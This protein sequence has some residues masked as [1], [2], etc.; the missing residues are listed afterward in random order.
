MSPRKTITELESFPTVI[1]I[2]VVV[3]V[4]IL[5]IIITYLYSYHTYIDIF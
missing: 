3:V 2:V 4:V 1:I 5:M